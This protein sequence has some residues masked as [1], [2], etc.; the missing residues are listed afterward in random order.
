MFLPAT[1]GIRRR[2]QAAAI[3]DTFS[4]VTGF[5]LNRHE[6]GSSC[7]TPALTLPQQQSLSAGTQKSVRLKWLRTARQLLFLEYVQELKGNKM[8]C[9]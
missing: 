2:V 8:V 4:H 5:R 9:G 1:T 3:P 6:G 7:D